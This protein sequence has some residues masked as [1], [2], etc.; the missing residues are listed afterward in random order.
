MA[1]I[2]FY[3]LDFN[4]LHILPPHSNKIGYKAINAQQDF[5]GSGSFELLFWDSNLKELVKKYRDNMLIVWRDFQGLLTSY[6]F[7][8]K[9]NHLYGTHINGLLHRAIIPVRSE[10]TDTVENLTNLAVNNINWLGF[11]EPQTM[12]NTVT[13]S[14]DK[15]TTADTYLQKLFEVGECGYE[16]KADFIN[17]RY[18]LGI[19]TTRQNPLMLSA[20]NLNAYEFETNY[21]G[22]E[23]AFGGWYKLNDVWTYISLDDTK[24]GIHKIDTVLGATTK[25]E[26]LNEL[27]QKKAEHKITMNTRRIEYGVDY[28]IGDVLRVQED[29]VTQ[30]KLINGIMRWDESGYGEKPILTDYEE[31]MA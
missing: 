4:L 6:K 3:D 10:K 17:K 1:D 23:I 11:T 30:H 27:K 13:Y 7:N 8:D 12:T 9:E 15:P 21:I 24:S 29:G 14:T 20:A 18:K 16:L 19:I 2:R 5:N 22:K 28:S 26:A 25:A 31:A